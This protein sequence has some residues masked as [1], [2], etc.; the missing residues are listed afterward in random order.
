MSQNPHPEIYTPRALEELAQD[1][2]VDPRQVLAHLQ[3]HAEAVSGMQQQIQNIQGIMNQQHAQL[4][5]NPD[6]AGLIT[7]RSAIEAL[8]AQHQEQ[9]SM[10]RTF[11]R[12]MQS[13]LNRLANRATAPAVRTAVP[14][15]IASKFKGNSEEL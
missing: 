12:D 7:L 2:N 10:Q 3:S 13:I 4:N 1:P 14:Q 5:S 15:P 11:E 6:P 9:R 8:A